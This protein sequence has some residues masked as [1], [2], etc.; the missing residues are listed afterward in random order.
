MDHGQRF[1]HE[2]PHETGHENSLLAQGC[3]RQTRFAAEAVLI[4]LGL[5]SRQRKRLAAAAVAVAGCWLVRNH[6][7]RGQIAG[8]LFAELVAG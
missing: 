4:A 1:G 6:Q 8:G 3:F 5:V 7:V 2:K